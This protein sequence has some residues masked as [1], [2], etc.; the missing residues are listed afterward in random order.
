MSVGI[1]IAKLL[2]L[3]SDFSSMQ[4][5]SQTMNTVGAVASSAVTCIS[6]KSA[7]VNTTKSTL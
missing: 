3:A 2:P 6:V 4:A 7:F 5:R 1:D